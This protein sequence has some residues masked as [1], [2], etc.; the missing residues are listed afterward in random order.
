M[1]S[2]LISKLASTEKKTKSRAQLS[3]DSRYSLLP[4]YVAGSMWFACV[5]G[6]VDVVMSVDDEEKEARSD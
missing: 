5:R 4:A 3:S 6:R 2:F 1:N